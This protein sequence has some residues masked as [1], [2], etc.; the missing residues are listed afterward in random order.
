MLI[1]DT[2]YAIFVKIKFGGY[3]YADN[4]ENQVEEDS[5]HLLPLFFL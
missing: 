1:A 2:N 3:T 5:P 4:V